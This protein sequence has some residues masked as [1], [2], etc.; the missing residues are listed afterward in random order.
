MMMINYLWTYHDP[1]FIK[2]TLYGCN[3]ATL[4]LILMIAQHAY[5]Y[6]PVYLPVYI[7]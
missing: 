4:T 6:L 1:E 2:K 5:F 3:S 7:Y